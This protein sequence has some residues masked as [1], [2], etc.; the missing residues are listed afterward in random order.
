VLQFS[1]SLSNVDSHVGPV[2]YWGVYAGIRRIPTSGFFWQRI[3]TSVI[4]NKQGTFRPFTTPLCVYPPPFLA[5]QHCVGHNIFF[6]TAS[7][8]VLIRLPY[9]A[10]MLHKLYGACPWRISDS[11]FVSCVT[12]YSRVIQFCT[13]R[14]RQNFNV[15]RQQSVT[16]SCVCVCVAASRSVAASGGFGTVSSH[17]LR[18]GPPALAGLFHGG[19]PQLRSRGGSVPGPQSSN[20][21]STSLHTDSNTSVSGRPGLYRCHHHWSIHPFW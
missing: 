7:L 18:E 11:N 10:Q 14:C 4:T 21:S 1:I 6:I 15:V 2:V 20:S 8:L 16:G 17:G 13:F 3:L 9:V 19:M 12:W 5:I